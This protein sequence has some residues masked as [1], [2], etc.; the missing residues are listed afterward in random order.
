MCHILHIAYV[1]HI[2][3]IN[4]QVILY[5]LL[6]ANI[7]IKLDHKQYHHHHHYSFNSLHNK[8]GVHVPIKFE[9]A[10]FYTWKKIFEWKE[11]M[12]TLLFIWAITIHHQLILWVIYWY[13]DHVKKAIMNHSAVTMNKMANKNIWCMRMYVC[14]LLTG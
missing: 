6:Q 4:Y 2:C 7:H 5:I 9:W 10:I 11:W 14:V 3:I 12:I 13:D 1:L 8:F